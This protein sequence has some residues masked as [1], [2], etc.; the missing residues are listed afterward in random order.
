MNQEKFNP[1]DPQHKKEGLK[2]NPEQSGDG[3]EK[4][5]LLRKLTG[6]VQHASKRN[7]DTLFDRLTAKNKDL[8]EDLSSNK[9]IFYENDPIVPTSIVLDQNVRA[10]LPQEFYD[11]PTQWIE[12]LQNIDRK[13]LKSKEDLPKGESIKELW[14][15]PY[16]ISRVKEIRLGEGAEPIVAVIKRIKNDSQEIEISEKAYK[17]GIPTPKILGVVNDHGNT[18]AFFEKLS[19]ISLDAAARNQGLK[20]QYN[21]HATKIEGL[22]KSVGANSITCDFEVPFVVEERLKRVIEK[23]A[24]KNDAQHYPLKKLGSALDYALQPPEHFSIFDFK[25]LLEDAFNYYSFPNDTIEILPGDLLPDPK[26]FIESFSS[27]ATLRERIRDGSLQK[28]RGKIK[29]LVDEEDE[30]R[31]KV[32]EKVTTLFYKGMTGRDI[33]KEL[34]RYEK[35]LKKEGIQHMDFKDR[36]ILIRWNEKGNHPL[37]EAGAPNLWI[38][39]WEMPKNPSN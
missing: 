22:I 37:I 23:S 34:K 10:L 14:Q 17:A 30:K 31:E 29:E 7:K 3:I 5:K 18:Y 27:P 11:N 26:I 38:I 25:A 32:A 8:I 16:D 20:Y 24:L 33:G 35:V 6:T 2:I 39:D 28:L 9:P 1:R 15:N 4:E 36:N 19:A 13:Y 21:Y 12:S